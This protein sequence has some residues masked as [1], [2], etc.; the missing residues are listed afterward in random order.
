MEN[1]KVISLSDD[2]EFIVT[3]SFLKL[4]ET[5]KSLKNTKGR[6]IAVIGAPGVGKSS[7]IFH[8]LNVLDLNVYEPILLMKNIDKSPEEVYVKIFNTL[9]KDMKVKTENEVFDK[10]SKFDAVLVA[11]KFLDSEFLD[12]SKAGLA[13]WTDSKGIMSFPLF[14]LW[15]FEYLIHKKDLKK[16][17]L[18]FQTAWTIQIKGFK[19]DLIT[20]FGVFSELVAGI[21]KMLFEVVEIKYEESE[22]IKIVK[23]HFKNISDEEIKLCIKKY[24]N[25]PRFI[26]S[27]LEGESKTVKTSKSYIKTTGLAD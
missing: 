26:L 2:G 3:N 4:Y 10:F 19:Y 25:K 13:R 16:V 17:N 12:P 6:I 5:L 23:S 27:A 24:G 14:F 20:D 11:D 7:N 21:L 15:I 8:A 9:K 1:Y 22:T 18:V